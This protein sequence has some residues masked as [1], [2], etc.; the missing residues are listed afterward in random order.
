MENS[1]RL[2]IIVAAPTGAAEAAVCLESLRPQAGGAEIIVPFS[3]P[4]ESAANLLQ[5]Y[6]GVRFLSAPEG[7][8]VFQLRSIGIDAASTPIV[9]LTEGHCT[10]SPTWVDAIVSAIEEGHP[11]VGGPIE[12][13]RDRRIYDW[14]VY[15]SEYLWYIPPLPAGPIPA[16]SGVN[17]AYRRELLTRCHAVWREAFYE[18][19][20]HAAL[21]ACGYGFY[22]A[23][24][25]QVDSH[26]N[27][28]QNAA[29]HL[30]RGGKRYAWH[31]QLQSPAQRHLVWIGLA[32]LVP[33]VLLARIARTLV[34]RRPA[35]LLTLAL[36]L[37][38]VAYLLGAW[39]AGELV[40][41][42]P[43]AGTRP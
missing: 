6:T 34:Q 27:T 17:V 16:L 33:V 10:V 20:V 23:P 22:C 41:S 13:G 42:F 1:P 38:Y 29:A 39:S 7:T 24:A 15:F 21:Q 14:A 40:G 9:A 12:N 2:S 8:S 25:M 30:Y 4:P 32:P 5:Q 35:R 18:N 11:I 37:P 3:G 26:L 19:E 28:L 43:A 31:R 36:A